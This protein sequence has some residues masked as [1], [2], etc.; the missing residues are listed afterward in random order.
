MLG[1]Y[2][3]TTQNSKWVGTLDHSTEDWMFEADVQIGPNNDYFGTLIRFTV[4]DGNYGTYGDEILNIDI[5]SDNSIFIASD[6]HEWPDVY[7]VTEPQET[8]VKLALKV[9]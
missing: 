7:Q 5:T 1:N 2:W 8:G 4:T 6:C 3:F 9:K